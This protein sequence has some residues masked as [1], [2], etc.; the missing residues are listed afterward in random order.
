MKQTH[1]PPEER[2]A[3]LKAADNERKWYSLDDKR[4]CTICDRIFTGRQIDI[5]RDRRGHYLFACPTPC[6]PANINQWLLCEVSPALYRE[7]IDPSQREFSF[8]GVTRGE[9]GPDIL[10]GRS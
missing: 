4:F 10:N 6:C 7:E 9:S 5:Q 2:L 1:F 8:L 3:I